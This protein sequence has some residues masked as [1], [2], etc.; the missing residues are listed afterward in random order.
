VKPGFPLYLG[1]SGESSPKLWDLDGDGGMEIIL[2]DGAGR[3]H[4][5]R[6]DATELS[7]GR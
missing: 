5:I 6:A 4:A 1:V 3:V 2:G 7:A